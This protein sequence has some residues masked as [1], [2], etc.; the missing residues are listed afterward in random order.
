MS[1]VKT[2]TKGF[3]GTITLNYGKKLNALSSELIDDIIG[4]IKDMERL[5]MRCV[6]LRAEPGIKVFSAGHDIKELPRGKRDPLSYKDPLRRVIRAIQK[7]P[8]PVIAMIEGTVWG[9][10]FETIM[11][12]DMVF[13]DK[14]STFAMT[15]VNLGVAYDIVGVHNLV[16]GDCSAHIIKELFF[17]ARPIS[18]ERAERAGIVNRVYDIED[19]EAAVMDVA[20]VICT[21]AP[22]SV[23]LIK[24]ELRVLSEA[25][26]LTPGEFQR[27]QGIRRTVY[28]SHDAK[29][30]IDAFFEK[31]KPVFTGE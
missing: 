12:C 21:K 18:A 14:R 4:A 6:I 10:A 9:G 1:Y 29:E 24:E 25:S 26:P 22:L 11:S 31:R 27:L 2:E 23:A 20:E 3:V 13:A 8:A 28:D 16:R 30:G 15:P 7:C 19:L 17:T 5:K